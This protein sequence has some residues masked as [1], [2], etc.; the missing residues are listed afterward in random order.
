[1][2][3]IPIILLNYFIISK[4]RHP[5]LIHL[6]RPENKLMCFTIAFMGGLL[7]APTHSV[8]Q[9]SYIGLAIGHLLVR[10]GRYWMADVG[11]DARGVLGWL[12]RK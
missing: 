9:L 4:S 6:V 7:F 12:G 5:F 3:P 11:K 10:G 2:L 8:H 1:M